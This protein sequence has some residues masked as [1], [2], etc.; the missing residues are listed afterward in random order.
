MLPDLQMFIQSKTALTSL[1]DLSG[2]KDG[3]FRIAY[4]PGIGQGAYQKRVWVMVKSDKANKI[5]HMKITG[6]HY[7]VISIF[8][9]YWV[10][11]LDFE[12]AQK[13]ELVIVRNVDERISLTTGG[14]NTATIVITKNK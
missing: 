10:T 11:S 3:W 6:D 2:I 13:K 7:Y 1:D 5:T 12:S 14:K 8:C 4:T 9:S